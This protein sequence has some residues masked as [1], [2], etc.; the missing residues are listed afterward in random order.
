MTNINSKLLLS[1][2][3]GVGNG[4]GMESSTYFQCADGESIPINPT[5]TR[6]NVGNRQIAQLNYSSILYTKLRAIATMHKGPLEKH[7]F[8]RL[9]G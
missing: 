4:G 2:F 9:C 1:P 3:P 8:L 5:Y 7:T 6:V